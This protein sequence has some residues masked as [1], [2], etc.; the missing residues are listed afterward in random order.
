MET[1]VKKAWSL[2]L[3]QSNNNKKKKNFIKKNYF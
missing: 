2:R 3:Y 1:V